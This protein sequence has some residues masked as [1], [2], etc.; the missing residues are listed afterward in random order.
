MISPSSLG[1]DSESGRRTLV[2]KSSRVP[3]LI[4]TMSGLQ[5]SK[6]FDFKLEV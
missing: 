6:F 5:S 3:H 4:A 1:D 2:D